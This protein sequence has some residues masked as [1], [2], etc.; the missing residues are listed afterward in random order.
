MKKLSDRELRRQIEEKLAVPLWPHAGQ[1]LGLKRGAAY[2]AAAAGKIE[3][4]D[5]VSRL[6]AVPTA[7]LKAKLRMK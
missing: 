2:A 3:T 7:W 5:K 1:A 4:V 6:K